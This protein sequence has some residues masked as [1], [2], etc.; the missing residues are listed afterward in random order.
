MGERIKH[1]IPHLPAPV[2][3]SPP[4]GCVVSPFMVRSRASRDSPRTD[5]GTLEIN[6]LAVRPELVEGETANDDTTPRGR[7]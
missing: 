5:K 2:P 4:G 6:Y 3:T 1:Q 7:G